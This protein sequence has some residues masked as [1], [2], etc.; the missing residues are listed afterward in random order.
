[1]SHPSPPPWLYYPVVN[2]TAYEAQQANFLKPTVKVIPPS[3]IILKSTSYDL[4]F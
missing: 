2:N 3:W 1:M 4:V